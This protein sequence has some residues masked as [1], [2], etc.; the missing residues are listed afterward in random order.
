MMK[1]K[2]TEGKSFCTFKKRLSSAQKGLFDFSKGSI[3]FFH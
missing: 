2:K 1:T 3:E